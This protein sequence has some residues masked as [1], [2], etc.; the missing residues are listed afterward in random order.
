MGWGDNYANLTAQELSRREQARQ[1]DLSNYVQG[2]QMDLQ[3]Q[4]ARRLAQKQAF[5]EADR[6]LGGF[7]QLESLL[8]DA[9]SHEQAQLRALIANDPEGAMQNPQFAQ[10]REQIGNAYGPKLRDYQTQLMMN[11]Q[12]L[13][14]A[15]HLPKD[16]Q[17]EAELAAYKEQMKAFYQAQLQG[18]RL[19][20][21]NAPQMKIDPAGNIIGIQSTEDLMR[22]QQEAY[23]AAQQTIAGGGSPPT[24]FRPGTPRTGPMPPQIPGTAAVDQSPVPSP[25]QP[26]PITPAP[27]PSVQAPGVPELLR[28]PGAAQPTPQGDNLG[29]YPLPPPPAWAGGAQPTPATPPPPKASPKL[30]IRNAAGQEQSINV[31]DWAKFPDWK[32]VGVEQE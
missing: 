8:P 6:Q 28:R 26:R 21:P 17:A 31:S 10:L 25:W 1:F 3:R 4:A 11:Q 2:Q 12:R 15:R 20:M 13:A 7:S 14:Q 24:P 9:A 32:P 29:V 16:Y 5:D 22:A 27:S 19:P 30:R 18:A 23:A